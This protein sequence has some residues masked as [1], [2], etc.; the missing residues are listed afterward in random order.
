MTSSKS[1]HDNYTITCRPFEEDSV[2]ELVKTDSRLSNWP[3][4]YILS[5][6][7]EVYVGETLDYDKRMRQ[8]LDNT[9]KQGLQV[10]HVILHEKFN[11]SVC[12]DLESTLINL[13]TG[14]GQRKVLNANNGIVNADYY[15][16][17]HYRRLFDDIFDNL[18]RSHKLFSH[19]KSD[20]ENSDLYKYSPF[21][22]L[23]EEQKSTVTSISE[24]IIDRRAN[25][26]SD[27]LEFI[28]EGGAG[29][30]K[31][32]LAVYLMK[33]IADYGSGYTIDDG[34]GPLAEDNLDFPSVIDR[35]HLNIG[36]VIPQASLR[37]TIKKVFR[38]VEGLD[39]SM[40]LSPFDIP[41]IVLD[42]SKKFDLLIID[43]AH[44]LNRFAAQANGSLLNQYRQ[45]NKQLY[46]MDDPE[47][48][49]HTQLD[50]ARDCSKNLILLLDK[51]QA[52]RPADIDSSDWEEAINRAKSASLHFPLSSQMRMQV[53]EI[54][55]YK[56][57]IDAIFGDRPITDDDVPDFGE[58]DF[59][60]FT[61]FGEM[62]S[63]LAE[64]E[65]K[66]GLSR[67]IAGYAWPWL[68]KGDKTDAAPFDIELDGVGMRWNRTTNSWVHSATAFQEVGSIHTIQGY[69]LNYAGVIIG[70]DV[71]LD[72]QGNYRVNRDNYHDRRGK[73]NNTLANEVTSPEQ[74]R[75]YVANIYKVLLTRGIRG[76]YVY[77]ESSGLAARLHQI[78]AILDKR[79]RESIQS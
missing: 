67:I 14:D 55:R 38:S 72:S 48:N 40:I 15:L 18:R 1:V 6:P 41:K 34:P 56:K 33:L 23:N 69:D 8:H 20:I 46:G 57:L 70:P 65:E 26:H 29:T 68:S 79:Q 60:I 78:Q 22:Q 11:K 50:W 64:R 3:V 21:K 75:E 5:S 4:V 47:G 24:R 74:L 27:L 63:V 36:L 53:S 73:A 43:E 42:R 39:A 44:R 61:D 31:T 62:R 45:Y 35:R 71:E 37:D 58:Y 16:R 13:F 30:G 10:T 12:L 51:T 7:K 17:E 9:Q 49:H 28:I 19:S 59:R 76:T 54:N 2:K 77:A 66:C 52:V 32:I 25:D